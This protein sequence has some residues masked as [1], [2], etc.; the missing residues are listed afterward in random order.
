MS[1]P[2]W[3]RGVAGHSDDS[4]SNEGG[5][6]NI[7]SAFVSHQR[8]DRDEGVKAM[9][10]VVR[11]EASWSPPWT[12][13]TASCFLRRLVGACVCALCYVSQ[14]TYTTWIVKTYNFSRKN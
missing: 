11:G 6:V 2:Y 8:R 13:P 7:A 3:T 10:P 1:P 5:P 12:T 4:C 9:S 14:Y